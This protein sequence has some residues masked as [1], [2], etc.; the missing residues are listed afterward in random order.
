[1]CEINPKRS[2]FFQ[3]EFFTAHDITEDRWNHLVVAT[4]LRLEEE[5]NRTGEI[6]VH[7]HESQPYD[8]HEYGLSHVI[9]CDDC[10]KK[11]TDVVVQASTKRAG[12]TISE[13][14]S[15][16]ARVNGKLGGRPRKK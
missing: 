13:A 8:E 16:A 3:L 15:E 12:S 1:M 9:N 14:K 5:S 10:F 4:L 11:I 6:R 2:Q 7:V